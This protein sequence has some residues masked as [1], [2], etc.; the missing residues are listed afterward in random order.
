MHTLFAYWVFFPAPPPSQG[1]KSLPATSVEIVETIVLL[2]G[3]VALY[4]IDSL[5]SAYAVRKQLKKR[6]EQDDDRE[7]DPQYE[8]DTNRR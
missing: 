3:L 1:D 7:C 6:L 8:D 5:V 2:L 4:A